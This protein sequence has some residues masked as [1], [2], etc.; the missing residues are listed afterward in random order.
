MTL[1]SLKERALRNPEVNTEYERL[2]DEFALIDQL[3]AMRSQAGLTQEQV[4]VRMNTQKSNISR[5][6]R[7]NGNPSWATLVKYAHACGFSLSLQALKE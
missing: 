1:Q 7:G 4:A 2:H 3:I 5:L 6:E